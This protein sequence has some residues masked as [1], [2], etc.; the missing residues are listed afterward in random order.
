MKKIIK[1]E[2]MSCSNCARR[3]E[4]ALKKLGNL[5]VEVNLESKEAIIKGDLSISSSKLK[6]VIEDLGYRV[7][8][9]N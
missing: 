9:I 8:S 1:I 4:G 3:V 2:G 6:E 7:K 5:E